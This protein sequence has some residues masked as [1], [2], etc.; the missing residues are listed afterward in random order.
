MVSL[1]SGMIKCSWLILCV[2]R[3]GPVPQLSVKNFDSFWWK[4]EFKI[5][6]LVTGSTHCY[7]LFTIAESNKQR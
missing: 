1:L 7:W 6:D 5:Y 4:T 2:S 3:L